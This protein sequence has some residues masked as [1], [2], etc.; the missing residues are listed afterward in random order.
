MTNNLEE[1]YPEGVEYIR[2]A[3]AEHGEA[4]VLENY[5]E[6]LYPLGVSDKLLLDLSGE[7]RRSR[8]L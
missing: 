2:Q 3:V 8:N 4:W 7:T 1:E 5:H 6:Q